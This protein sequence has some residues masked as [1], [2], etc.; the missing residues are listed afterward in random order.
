[1]RFGVWGYTK[2]VFCVLGFLA[3]CTQKSFGLVRKFLTK[4]QAQQFD[5]Q[6]VT[7]RR[8]GGRPPRVFFKFF[9]FSFP[10]L[11]IFKRFRKFL[12]LTENQQTKIFPQMPIF[13]RKIFVEKSIVREM[14]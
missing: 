12:Q 14:F 9:L 4:W 1:L 8:R 10:N 2:L 3:F 13:V 6:C 7:K 11:L 5:Y